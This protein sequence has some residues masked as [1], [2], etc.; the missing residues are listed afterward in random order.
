MWDVW[1]ELWYFATHCINAH[2]HAI[3]MSPIIAQPYDGSWDPLVAKV[4]QGISFE[5]AWLSQ[6]TVGLLVLR[7]QSSFAGCDA[8]R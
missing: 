2:A 1:C 6:G 5:S 7:D 4:G 3:K 8:I